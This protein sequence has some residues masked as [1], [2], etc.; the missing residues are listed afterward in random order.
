[1]KDKKK[2]KTAHEKKIEIL[3]ASTPSYGI[4]ID[5]GSVEKLAEAISMVGPVL[6]SLLNS[7]SEE[8]TK[9]MALGVLKDSLPS[10]KNCNISDTSINIGK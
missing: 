5:G 9:I 7:E 2:A 8:K 6:L 3:K 10:V 4:Y 1:M